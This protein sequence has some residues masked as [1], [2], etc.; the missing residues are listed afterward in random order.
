L[1]DAMRVVG[2]RS[3]IGRATVDKLLE[4]VAVSGRRIRD[5]LGFKP[6]YDLARGWRH[7]LGTGGGP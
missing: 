5:E 1:E 6:S 2:R 7:A 4:D 3:P